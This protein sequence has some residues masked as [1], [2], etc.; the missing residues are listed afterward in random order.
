VRDF[1]N[2][3]FSKAL[4]PRLPFLGVKTPSPPPS[5]VLSLGPKDSRDVEARFLS[6][7]EPERPIEGRTT[8]G[9]SSSSSAAELATGA[10]PDAPSSSS[11]TLMLRRRDDCLNCRLTNFIAVGEGSDV[12]IEHQLLCSHQQQDGLEN[13]TGET[14]R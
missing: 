13:A 8:A 12:A 9:P 6:F 14:N 2:E 5:A 7:V 3:L 10:P 4:C 1:L 11:L